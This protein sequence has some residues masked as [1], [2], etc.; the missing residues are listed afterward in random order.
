MNDKPFDDYF[1]RVYDNDSYNCAHLVCE[2]WQDITG[3]DLSEVL[4]GFLQPV[5]DRTA[6]LSIKNK[7][8]RSK[9]LVSPCIVLMTH[10]NSEPHVGIYIDGK[11]LHIREIGVHYQPL[12]MASFGYSNRRYYTCNQE[13]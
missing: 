9:E 4:K 8:K 6:E 11:V 12:E 5:K 2:A 3:D 1:N 13:K 7:L 10:K